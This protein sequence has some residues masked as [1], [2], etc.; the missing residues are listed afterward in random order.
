MTRL[1]FHEVVYYYSGSTIDFYAYA[2]EVQRMHHHSSL[3]S[4]P[5]ES[6]SRDYHHRV[7]SE[8][9]KNLEARHIRS[10]RYLQYAIVC[11]FRNTAPT[12][13]VL[14]NTGNMRKHREYR[15]TQ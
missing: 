7:F 15:K 9:I 13:E 10:E 8:F 1:S 5:L 3:T 2:H 6:G 14:K 4:Q 12:G 11:M